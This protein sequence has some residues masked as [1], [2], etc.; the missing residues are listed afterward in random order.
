[1]RT[2]LATALLAALALPAPAQELAGWNPGVMSGG[3]LASRLLQR[4][5]FGTGGEE[6]GEIDNLVLGPGGE[7]RAIVVESGGI[8]PLGDVEFRVPWR[9]VDF[10]PG[11]ESARVPVA[12]ERIEDFDLGDGFRLEPGEWLARDVIGDP[13]NLVGQDA[14][15][16]VEDLVLGRDGRLVAILIEGGGLGAE[17]LYAVPPALGSF[18]P[19]HY[20]VNLPY[21]PLELGTL[22]PFQEEA[23]L[24][25]EDPFADNPG[26]PNR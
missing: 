16:E 25:P 14:F 21:T 23:L 12:D 9:Q 5:V 15:G 2:I 24:P 13:V 1:M 7:V 18:D 10:A 19:G 4:E 26:G 6:I 20:A 22:N 11:F 8:G 17:A 3:F